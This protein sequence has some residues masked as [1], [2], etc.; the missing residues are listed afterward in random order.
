MISAKLFAD[1][2]RAPAGVSRASRFARAHYVRAV[3]YGAAQRSNI[4]VQG[5]LDC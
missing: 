4:V 2:Q 5:W 3:L 1:D